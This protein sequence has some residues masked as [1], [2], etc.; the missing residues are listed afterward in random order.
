MKL[1]SIPWILRHRLMQ[2]VFNWLVFV[3]Q[4][5]FWLCVYPLYRGINSGVWILRWRVIGGIADLLVKTSWFVR[6]KISYPLV[7]K[8]RSARWVLRW[9]VIKPIS[10]TLQHALWFLRWKIFYPSIKKVYW[11][12]W[13]L[14]WRVIRP[15]SDNLLYV[16]WFLRWK[17][18][19]PGL[20][21]FLPRAIVRA[22]YPARA[23]G[24]IRFVKDLSVRS[25]PLRYFS[26]GA[27]Q[28][29]VPVMRLY[30]AARVE[31]PRAVMFPVNTVMVLNT[32]DQSYDF[33]AICVQMIH[34]ATVMGRSN[35]VFADGTLQHH[36]LYRFSHDF[37]SEE[38]HGKIRILPA[39][40]V[41][42]RHIVAPKQYFFDQAAMF[43]DSCSSN[44]AHW[45]TEVLPR[46]NAYWNGPPDA[47][48]ANFERYICDDGQPMPLLVDDKLHPNI[49]SSLLAVVGP[50]ARV[51]RV[52]NSEHVEVNRL[53]VTTPTGYVPFDRRSLSLQGHNEGV[54]SPAALQQLRD[55]LT[56][57]LPEPPQRPPKKIFLRRNTK[58]RAMLNA[59]AIEN[60]LVQEG[61]V[62][63][64]TELM[65]FAEQ[66]HTFSGAEVV[67]GA[68]GA[69]FA[70]LIF[71]KPSAKIVICIAIFKNTS[72]GYWQNLA[73]AAGNSVIYVLGKITPSVVKT[74]HSDFVIDEVDLLKALA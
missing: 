54:F 70:N 25:V 24:V 48:G 22:L 69:A 47:E 63:V 58:A 9:R 6:W 57:I 42:K 17:V 23:R 39:T 21:I 72:Y 8:L 53:M 71:C 16:L 74:I 3:Y 1:N 20:K 31:A 44:Y 26:H 67:V 50:K 7:Q 60:R 49:E 41:A 5:L 43:M 30:A 4:R 10:D 32:S 33:P 35:M 62:A 61:F 37:T 36:A 38:L 51:V 55:H 2:P 59:E 15:I 14:R 68:T 66:F 27:L 13:L 11:V 40:S 19:Y 34:K 46:I 52:A 28:T 45:L 65:S 56:A 29:D 64:S 12:R 18:L 73:C